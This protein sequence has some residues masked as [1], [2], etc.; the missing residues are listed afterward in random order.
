MESR[1]RSLWQTPRDRGKSTWLPLARQPTY[2]PN[3][4]RSRASSPRHRTLF[5]PL[6]TD[7]AQTSRFGPK[8]PAEGAPSA[9]WK[10]RREPS[11][12]RGGRPHHQKMLSDPILDPLNPEQRSAVTHGEGP[13]LILSGAGS[14]KT[15][16]LTHRVAYLIRDLAVPAGA[17][18]A[19][20]F[21]NK[22]AREMRE[23]LERL[24]GKERLAELTV[25]TFHAF[26]A[27]LLRREGP[28]VGI[29]RSYAIYDEADQRARARAVAGPLSAHPGR[30]VPGH[31]P[32]AVRSPAL[33][34]GVQ[35]EPRRRRRRRP[36]S[37]QLARRRCAEHPRLRARLPEREGREA[38]AELP[39]DAAH[40][41]RGALGGPQQRRA[42]GEASLDRSQG[43]RRRR[44]RAGVRRV[45]RSRG[46]RARDRASPARRPSPPDAR[47]RRALPHQ[48]PIP[49]DRGHLPRLRARLPGGRRRVLLSA[50][51]GEG[52]PRLPPVAPEP[53]GRVRPGSRAQHAA[54]R[55][56]R[57]AHPGRRD[58]GDPAPAAGSP[59]VLRDAHGAAARGGRR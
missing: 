16:V 21:T 26:C 30:R 43:R 36:V 52:H 27:R 8:R 35:A 4:D 37:V 22:A 47:C 9:T 53:A 2:P 29:D 5:H 31:Q 17:I 15:R 50:S 19:V 1:T 55:R 14:G 18:L 3:S 25:G 48:R 6:S 38:R 40:P 10:P 44:R 46:R 58:R 59:R 28:L 11:G 23:R 12:H 34:R 20:T 33:P 42:E 39:L 41:R 7:Y 13:L 32:R 57:L 54:P 24:V 49:G 45:T 51:R 56:G